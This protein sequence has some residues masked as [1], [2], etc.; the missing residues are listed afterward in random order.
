ML[1]FLE[2][3]SHLLFGDKG[4]HF[5][6]L[7]NKMVFGKKIIIYYCIYQFFVWL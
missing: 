6:I 1:D 5:V 4:I 7:K 3:L 2:V